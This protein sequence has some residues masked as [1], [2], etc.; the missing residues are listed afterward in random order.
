M[1]TG[2]YHAN[3]LRKHE[4]FNNGCTRCLRIIS[5]C[6]ETS[7]AK[8]IT[9]LSCVAVTGSCITNMRVAVAVMKVGGGGG[10]AA[11]AASCSGRTVGR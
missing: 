6:C 11:T 3:V 4:K 8:S 10:E 5:L 1:V 2:S 9:C 7:P